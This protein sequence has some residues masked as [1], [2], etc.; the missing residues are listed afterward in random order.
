MSNF[1]TPEQ[2][3]VLKQTH[4]TIHHD[5]RLVDRIKEILMLHFGFTYF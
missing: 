5:K 4:K 1:L 3:L 2:V